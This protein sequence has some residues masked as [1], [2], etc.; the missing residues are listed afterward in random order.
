MKTIPYDVVFGQPPRS[1]IVPDVTIKGI[2]DEN[3]DEDKEEERSEGHKVVSI[4]ENDQ[5]SGHV[6]VSEG[7]G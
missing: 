7:R 3:E 1:L 2:V 5:D 4:G 6:H